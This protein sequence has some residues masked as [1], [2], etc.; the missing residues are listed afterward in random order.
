MSV[1]SYILD[2]RVIALLQNDTAC[3]QCGIDLSVG[4]PVHS[5]RSASGIRRLYCDKCA[6]AYIEDGE[7]KYNGEPLY[8]AG[9][10]FGPTWDL[11][12]TQPEGPQA[13]EQMLIVMNN[14][15]SNFVIFNINLR[16]WNNTNY[17][18]EYQSDVQTYADWAINRTLFFGVKLFVDRYASDKY[19]GPGTNWRIAENEPYRSAAISMFVDM[20]E[21]WN[22][23][24]NFI[25]ISILTEPYSGQDQS[26]WNAVNTFYEDV[27]DAVRV[28]DPACLFFIQPPRQWGGGDALLVYHTLDDYIDRTGI[29]YE[30]H[31]YYDIVHKVGAWGQFYAIGNLVA[32]KAAYID[33]LDDRVMVVKGDGYPVYCGEFGNTHDRTT[34]VPNA[35]YW[36]EAFSDQMEVME[37]KG[38]HYATHRMYRRNPDHVYAMFYNNMTLT[39]AGDAWV[40]N[41]PTGLTK[42]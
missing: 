35:P 28:I 5:K 21:L 39:L 2:T 32:A 41:M 16:M 36:E 23:T 6:R 37:D 8:L 17:S 22:T 40:A 18:V 12:T 25:G 7:L 26:H 34:G 10:I 14:S 11:P 27:I 42:P 15:G 30:Y 3:I 9:A 19:C 20:A 24:P 1:H 38:I 4:D 33:W 29:I 31:A 13:K